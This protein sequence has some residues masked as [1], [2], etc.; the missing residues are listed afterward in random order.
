MNGGGGGAAVTARESVNVPVP[1]GLLAVSRTPKVPIWVGLPLINPV[2]VFIVSPVGR[3]L[4]AKLVGF[5]VAR[6]WYE[7]GCP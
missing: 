4:A 3:P 7:N 5:C 2:A 6:I 1:D